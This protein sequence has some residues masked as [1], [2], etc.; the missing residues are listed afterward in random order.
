MAFTAAAKAWLRAG[1][2]TSLL[3][4]FKPFTEFAFYGLPN[5]YAHTNHKTG[6]LHV[7]TSDSRKYRPLAV[8]STVNVL[9]PITSWHLGKSSRTKLQLPVPH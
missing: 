4:I 5:T 3:Q 7:N 9:R 1:S 8:S 2:V 6:V